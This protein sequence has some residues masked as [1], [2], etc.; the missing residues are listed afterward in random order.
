MRW[1]GR[2]T[3]CPSA[4][5]DPAPEFDD[6]EAL[7]TADDEFMRGVDCCSLVKLALETI[8][9]RAKASVGEAFH[10]CRRQDHGP[11]SVASL[12][13]SL[14]LDTDY[15][16]A[17]SRVVDGAVVDRTLEDW[18]V[19]TV[20][21][22]IDGVSMDEIVARLVPR[23]FSDGVGEEP[24]RA[25]ISAEF[26]RNYHAEFGLR[27]SYAIRAL[28]PDGTVIEAELQG[29]TPIALRERRP[30]SRIG[31]ILGDSPEPW[32]RLH[33]LPDGTPVVRMPSF[34]PGRDM[35]IGIG[36][37]IFMDMAMM[38]STVWVEPTCGLK[39][40]STF[41]PVPVVIISGTG[42][43]AKAGSTVMATKS[44]A[45]TTPTSVRATP[46]RRCQLEVFGARMK[47]SLGVVARAA[48]PGRRGH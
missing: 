48:S 17:L 32:P 42:S 14:R 13:R 18:P 1:Y 47:S 26:S 3:P 22:H 8:S 30:P 36:P 2:L 27:P 37:S 21:T 39:R 10:A 20:V 45:A 16:A 24:R 28:A 29:L 43:A 33:A 7:V 31:S 12:S 41:L 46:V 5:D 15:A 35:S 19:G 34:M 40:S 23:T 38:K 6:D 11:F 25:R 9:R 4:A 44:R